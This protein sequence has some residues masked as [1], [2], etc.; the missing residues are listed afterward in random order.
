M[1]G[2]IRKKQQT[3]NQYEDASD[4]V[5]SEEYEEDKGSKDI[6]ASKETGEQL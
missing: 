2:W 3:P 5:T 6:N 1:V 4:Q